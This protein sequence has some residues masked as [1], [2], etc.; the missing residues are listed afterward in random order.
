MKT[1]SGNGGVH[2]LIHGNLRG[3]DRGPLFPYLHTDSQESLGAI[4]AILRQ[5]EQNRVRQPRP[6]RAVD[7]LQRM[8]QR[9]GFK[10]QRRKLGKSGLE[11]SV[12]GLGCMGMSYYRGPAPDRN[13]MIELIRKAVELGVTFFDTAEVYG[14][15]YQRRTC[16]KLATGKSEQQKVGSMAV[17]ILGTSSP[18]SSH[19]PERQWHRQE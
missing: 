3:L 15:F 4:S 10:M 12:L 13:A 19:L 9:K 7:S 11:V 18:R 2:F 8:N 14:P 5:L 16:V 1:Y 6:C 17:S